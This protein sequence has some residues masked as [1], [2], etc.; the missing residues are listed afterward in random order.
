MQFALSRGMRAH[1]DIKPENLLIGAHQVLQIS[2]F[3]LATAVKRPF[4][5]GHTEISGTPR[6]MAPEQW[7]AGAQ[8]VQTDL[9]AFG[10]VLHELCVARFPWSANNAPE[11]ARVHLHVAP[12]IASHPLTKVIELC[13]AKS[14]LERPNGPQGLLEMLEAVAK[15]NKIPLP[16]RPEPLDD[17]QWDLLATSSLGTVGDPEAALNAAQI[18]TRR[19]P[20]F[21]SGWTQV[22]RILLERG[23]LAGA[24]MATKQA[25]KIDPTRTAPWN[26][27]GIILGRQGKYEA[28]V[29]ALKRALDAD[30][31][32][33][34][35]MSNLASPLQSLGRPAESIDYLTRA[36]KLAPDKYLLWAELGNL[37][38][39][40]G[41]N[42]D[43]IAALRRGIE[44]APDQAKS[45]IVLLLN[46]IQNRPAN[47]VRG[48]ALLVTGKIAESLPVLEAEAKAD[49]DNPAVAQNF[50]IALLNSGHEEK[51]IAVLENLHRMEPHNQFAWMSLMRLA[52]KRGD[53][54]EALRW[55]D[56][57]AAIPEMLAKSKAFRAYVLDE[58]GEL[59]KAKRLLAEAMSQHPGEPELFVAYGDI[60]MKH[61]VPSEA[62]QAYRVAIHRIK[63]EPY[64]VQWLRE[65]E[66]RLQRA[67]GA[68]REAN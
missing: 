67:V 64:N 14:P 28:A 59:Q 42:Q 32:N 66:A 31:D 11:L 9:Y 36:T 17:E 18:L 7:T 10:V 23:D 26:N 33:T 15:E 50:A 54:A 16:P 45:E 49:P 13:L 58:C 2:D 6:Y 38:A 39:S 53:L 44:L 19:W 43:A 61:R 56:R 46:A 1:R 5:G 3:G 27:L 37:Y 41:L 65:I 52:A 29:E 34:G 60:A 57:Y 21:A 62:V 4:E 47:N 40:L 68:A 51:A 35:A 55:C 25:I 48:S 24:E 12:Q 63:S 20:G 22:G 30:P 8:S